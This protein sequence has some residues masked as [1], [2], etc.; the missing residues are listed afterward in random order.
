[1]FE[2]TGERHGDYSACN[3]SRQKNIIKKIEVNIYLQYYTVY[4]FLNAH[5]NGPIHFK[6]VLFKGQLLSIK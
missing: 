2:K 3:I 4:N 1:M 5:M 6:P